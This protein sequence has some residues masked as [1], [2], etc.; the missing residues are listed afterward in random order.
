[1]L[2]ALRSL[3][4]SWVGIALLGLLIA[5]LLVF[6][7][8]QTGQIG[9]NSVVTAGQSTVTPA[10]YRLAYERQIL[11]LSQQFGRRL[12]PD[13]ARQFGLDNQVL[14]QIVT[15]VVLDEQARIMGLGTSQARQAATIGELYPSFYRANGE[16]NREQLRFE[17]RQQRITEEQFIDS[18]NSATRRQQIIEALSD[19][20]AA[21]RFF[22]DEQQRHQGQTRDVEL[23]E[24][25]DAEIVAIETPSDA[26]LTAYFE[27][28]AD[29]YRAPEYRSVMLVELTP[30][31]LAEES[32]ID[33]SMV[34]E[35]YERRID[36]YR[37]PE[38]RTVLQL[39]FPDRE[40]ALDA[41]A[42]VTD[43]TSI[44]AIVAELGR[45]MDD[46]TLG[47]FTQQTMP[48]QTLAETAFGLEDAGIVSDVVDGT[49]GPLL[50]WVSE[51]IPEQTQ[52]FE[53]V[54]AELR[55]TLALVEANDILLNVSDAYEDARAAGATMQ[56]AATSQRLSVISIEAVDATGRDKDG[57]LVSLPESN[58]L[59]RE[60]FTADI[61]TENPPLSASPDGFLW[62]EVA[63]IEDERART[64]DEIRERVIE[65]WTTDERNR[66][67]DEAAESIVAQLDAG[68]ILGSIAEEGGYTLTT[69]F[70]LARRTDDPDFGRAGVRSLFSVGPDANGFVRSIDGERRFIFRV[71]AVTDPL[72]SEADENLG[73]LVA[74]GIANDIF[75]QSII[76]L[77]NEFP[78]S[79]NQQAISLALGQ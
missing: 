47:T 42:R 67:L 19:G 60:I 46:V 34:R 21:P 11:T 58:E 57:E 75:Q 15:G 48:D 59:L 77:Q 44:D 56:E 16:F 79:V 76:K 39:V 20:I 18:I 9:A 53:E 51:I 28:N 49:F 54:E 35:E 30:Q 69:K 52:P 6:G 27:D 26:D 4:R 78:V 72:E 31:S 68:G 5:G 17:L 63:E 23:I 55:D 8:G 24:I 22:L 2:D 40:A 13:Q 32:A 37:Q 41:R 1:M 61:D 66:L 64:L 7:V 29:R 65:D 12:S 25:S 74:Q 38:Q 62:Y 33:I 14:N 45:S 71:T 36:N 43:G 50:V 70:G 3:S 73:E 10:E